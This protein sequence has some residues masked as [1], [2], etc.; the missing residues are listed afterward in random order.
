MSLLFDSFRVTKRF[1][2]KEIE[3]S[4]ILEDNQPMVQPLEDQN[5]QVTD[6]YA[7]FERAL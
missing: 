2:A 1:G 7:I 4:W 3:A 6:H 5:F